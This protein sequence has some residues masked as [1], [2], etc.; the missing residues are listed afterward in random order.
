VSDTVLLVG[1]GLIAVAFFIVQLGLIR[2]NK[3]LDVVHV[4][5]NSKMTAALEQIEKL[6]ADVA[7]QKGQLDERR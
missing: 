3:K 5:V 2:V 4:L 1:A 7:Y 6:K